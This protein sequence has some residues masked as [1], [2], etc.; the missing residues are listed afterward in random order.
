MYLFFKTSGKHNQYL[1]SWNFCFLLMRFFKDFPDLL[2]LHFLQWLTHF[3]LS[4][5]NC[6]STSYN[7]NKTM[8]KVLLSFFA[9]LIAFLLAENII[10]VVDQISTVYSSLL[11]QKVEIGRYDSSIF[12]LTGFGL[13][14]LEVISLQTVCK[15]SRKF[16]ESPEVSKPCRSFTVEYFATI[17]DRDDRLLTRNS[18][19]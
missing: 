8:A 19:K 15:C 5:K 7:M 14:N 12:L 9:I 6:S 3:G 18:I 1:N 13:P 2:K 16:H 11:Y 10:S 4:S 17:E